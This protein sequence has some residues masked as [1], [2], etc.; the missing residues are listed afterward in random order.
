[1]ERWFNIFKSI[2]VINHI[3]KMKSKNDKVM[4][5]NAEKAFD[6]I[7]HLFMIKK[8]GKQNLDIEGTFLRIIKAVFHKAKSHI[9]LSWRNA[10]SFYT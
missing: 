4:L 2:R 10:F 9:I 6:K 3:N 5:V 1:M 8:K 7:Q